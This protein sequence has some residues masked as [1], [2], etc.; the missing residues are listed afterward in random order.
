MG[1]RPHQH[2]SAPCSQ[3]IHFVK[4]PSCLTVSKF[5]QSP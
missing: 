3:E 5:Q 1:F 4:S 2:K